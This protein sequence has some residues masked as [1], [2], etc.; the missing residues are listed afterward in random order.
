MVAPATS[1]AVPTA[2]AS[3]WFAVA[4]KPR[5]ETL[6]Q[7][8]LQRQDYRVC[9]PT[10]TLRKRRQSGWQQVV[11]AMFPGYLFVHLVLGEDDVAPIRSTVGCRGMVRF[12]AGYTPIPDYVM[13]RLLAFNETPAPAAPDFKVGDI[14]RIEEGPFAGIEAIF[15]ARKGDDRVQLLIQML[16]QAQKVLVDGRWVGRV[17]A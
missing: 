8:H 3:A 4:T 16:G 9:L 6:A 17:D 14:V 10:V 13:Q 15:T 5:S 1:S 7:Q 2:T 11:E 12:G